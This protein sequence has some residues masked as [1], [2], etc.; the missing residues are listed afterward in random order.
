MFNDKSCFMFDL[1]GTL[2]DIRT[3]EDLPYLWMSLANFYSMNG[4]PYND[5]DL[6]LEY[7][8]LCAA[9]VSGLVKS[10]GKYKL[11]EDNY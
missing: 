11:S 9:E 10:S 8:R 4:A 2:A 5:T 6:R 3:D 1:Y 7:G